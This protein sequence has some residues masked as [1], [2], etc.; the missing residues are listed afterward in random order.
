MKVSN[1]TT[2]IMKASDFA[3]TNEFVG[4]YLDPNHP[5]C[6]RTIKAVSAT[7]IGITGFDAAAGEGHPCN[8]KTDIPWGPLDG[9]VTGDTIVIDFS[10]KGGPS[11]LT[12]TWTPNSKRI[13]W[14]DGNYWPMQMH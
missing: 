13:T 6:T 11:D 10:P 1:A 4:T 9:K 8:G 5:G 2:M 7:E 14:A 12:G 3:A